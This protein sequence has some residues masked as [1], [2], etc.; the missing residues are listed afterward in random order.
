M[1]KSAGIAAT[2]QAPPSAEDIRAKDQMRL[3]E[4]VKPVGEAAEEDLAV[5]RALM[6]QR[7]AEDIAAAYVRLARTRMPS[8]EDLVESEPE[9]RRYGA[10]SRFEGRSEGRK[11][12]PRP[13]FEDAVWFRIDL[14]RNKNAEARWLLPML[15]RRGHVTKGDIG[16]IRVF[17]RETRFE[18]AAGAVERFE[19]AVARGENDGGKVQRLEEGAPLPERDRNARPPQRRAPQETP[20]PHVRDQRD[21]KGEPPREK[22]KA[23]HKPWTPP[24]HDAASPKPPR[25]DRPPKGP[26]A[27]KPFPKKRKSNG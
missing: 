18:I 16:A 25:P 22:A 1:L 6:A 23:P 15:C 26:K 14:G 19:A 7:S 4:E 3:I 17:E 10:A 5:A 20:R 27:K 13:G 8:P 9:P 2:W 24:L 11:E 12:A 21:T